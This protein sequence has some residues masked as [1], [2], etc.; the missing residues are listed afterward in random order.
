MLADI[1]ST[2]LSGAESGK[3]KIGDSVVVF[4]QGPIG[5]CA[6]I[7]AKLMGASLVIG[8]DGDDSRLV[9]ARKMGVRSPSSLS[10]KSIIYSSLL[11]FL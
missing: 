9:M 4:A 10:I 5:L 6:S 11:S 2:G 1:A 8:V 3:V 7:G